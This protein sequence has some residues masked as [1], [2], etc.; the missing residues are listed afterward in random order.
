MKDLASMT[1]RMA[2]VQRGRSFDLPNSAPRSG[3]ST[4][5]FTRG[6]Q[7]AKPAVARRV[8]RRVR[9]R[10]ACTVL[11]GLPSAKR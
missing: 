1:V 3:R 7:T 9:P 8:Q 5:E 10:A 11:Y 2:V 4:F 6:L